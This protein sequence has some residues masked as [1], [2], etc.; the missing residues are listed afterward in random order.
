[1][2]AAKTLM[3]CSRRHWE[4][5]DGIYGGS[6]ITDLPIQQ[7]WYPSDNSKPSPDTAS[8]HLTSAVGMSTVMAPEILEQQTED[9]EARDPGVS[10]SPSVLLA[11]YMW[12]TNARR[13]AAL[14][15]SDQTELA[16][17]D[18]ANLH[19]DNE[20]YLEEVVHY[21]WDVSTTISL[22]GVIG[23]RRCG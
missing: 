8:D 20:K 11:A 18:V 6:S 2:A 9:W 1:M 10:R 5:E 23:A 3:R 12:G 4:F 22:A 15:S 7:C 21:C 13:F 14:S 17:R 16:I 19:S